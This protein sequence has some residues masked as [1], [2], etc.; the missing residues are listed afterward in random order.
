MQHGLSYTSF[1]YSNLTVDAAAAPPSV[2]VSFTVQ[3]TGAVLGKESAQLYLGFPAAAG[4]PPLQLRDFA[5]LP[6]APGEAVRVDMALDARACS[7][8]S[9]ADYAWARV[10]GEYQVAIGASSRDLRLRGSFTV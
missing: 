7:V 6:L 5:S 9:E 4:E 10:P 2:L 3:N 8:W 1:S